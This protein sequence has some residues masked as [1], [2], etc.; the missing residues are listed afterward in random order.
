MEGEGQDFIETLEKLGE[1]TLVF[2][3]RERPQLLKVP[4]QYPGAKFRLDHVL[5]S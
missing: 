1:F 5:A 4:K 2:P 3:H